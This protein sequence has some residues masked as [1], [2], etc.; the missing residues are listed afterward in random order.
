MQYLIRSVV[1]ALAL[2]VSFNSL[3]NAQTSKTKKKS[4][5]LNQYCPVAYSAMGKAMK[6]DAKYSSK[7]EGKTYYMMSADAKKMFDADPAKYLPKY[8]GYCTTALAMGKKLKSDPE[9][10]SAYKAATYLFSSREAK[11]GFDKD[12]EATIAMADKQFAS[13]EKAQH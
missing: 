9:I 11:S 13:L 6:G 7:Y 1:L 10:F 3:G 12:P 5:A 2:V 8:N 4:V